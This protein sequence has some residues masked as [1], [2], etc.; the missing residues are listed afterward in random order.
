MSCRGEILG[1]FLR[2]STLTGKVADGILQMIEMIIDGWKDLNE[3]KKKIAELRKDKSEKGA[4][5]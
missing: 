5:E 3:A 2:V 1:N 4:T